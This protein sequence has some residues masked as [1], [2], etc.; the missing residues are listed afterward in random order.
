[1][2]S[3]SFQDGVSCMLGCKSSVIYLDK[4]IGQEKETA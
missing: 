3:E 1:M 4:T 2:L